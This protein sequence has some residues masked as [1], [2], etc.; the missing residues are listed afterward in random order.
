[1]RRRSDNDICSGVTNQSLH[2]SDHDSLT[3]K[4]DWYLDPMEYH[5]V[6][7]A[8][9]GRT[10]SSSARWWSRFFPWLL[11]VL[12]FLPIVLYVATNWFGWYFVL[13]IPTLFSIYWEAN[14]TPRQIRKIISEQLCLNCGYTLSH[15]P[16]DDAGRGYC[17]ECGQSFLRDWYRVPKA[18]YSRGRL[19]EF[20]R[21][22]V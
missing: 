16:T 4:P 15:A 3:F 21:R 5:Y 18:G 13:L 2:P 11:P 6:M 17:S 9:A 8:A 19:D 1:M 22:D 10:M 14:R 7:H 12:M 20:V